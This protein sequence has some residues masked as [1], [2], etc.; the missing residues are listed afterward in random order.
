[1]KR[2]LLF[3]LC[4]SLT[5]S[6]LR[7]SNFVEGEAYRLVCQLYPNGCLM[8]GSMH[9]STAQIY[10]GTT[11]EQVLQ[12][13]ATKELTG[14]YLLPLPSLQEKTYSAKEVGDVL[15]ISAHQVGALAN[16]HKMKDDEHGQW[17]KDK[18]PYTSKEVSTF[19]YYEKAIEELRRILA[20]GKEA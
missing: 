11:Y 9:G 14:E 20:N 13:H 17:F 4:V 7:A 12:A 1:M 15:G 16:K 8:L 2:I 19:R 10:H 6:M 3:M 5:T 18:S